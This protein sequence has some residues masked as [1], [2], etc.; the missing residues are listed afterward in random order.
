MV[1]VILLIMAFSFFR[2]TKKEPKNFREVLDCLKKLEK[3][4]SA[5]TKDLDNLK[6]DFEFSIKKVGIIRYNPFSGI[7]GNQSF[8]IALLNGKNSGFVITGLYTREGSR[9][10]A[11]SIKEGKSQFLLSEEEKEAI[12]RAQTQKIFNERAKKI[13]NQ[14]ASGGGLRPC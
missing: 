8:S 10:Y 9:V 14:A 2:K 5:L 6:S 7:G 1:S 3:N 13:N 11:K 12:K 4:I